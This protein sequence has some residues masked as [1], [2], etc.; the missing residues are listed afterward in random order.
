MIGPNLVLIL[1]RHLYLSGVSLGVDLRMDTKNTC[2]LKRD[3]TE[4]STCAL[5]RFN[6]RLNWGDRIDC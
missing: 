5:S 4:S 6:S 3:R 1:N 2:V